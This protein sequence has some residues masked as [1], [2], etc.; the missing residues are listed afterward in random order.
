MCPPVLLV[1]V[2]VL[3]L[4]ALEASFMFRVISYPTIAPM[5]YSAPLRP[6]VPDHFYCTSNTLI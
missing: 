2:H 6:G 4:V 1:R 5:V 3:I